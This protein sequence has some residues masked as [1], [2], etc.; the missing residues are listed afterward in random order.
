[1]IIPNQLPQIVTAARGGALQALALQAGQVLDGRVLGPAPNGGTQVQIEGK[2]LNLVLPQAAKAGDTLRFEVQ[3]S[4]AQVRLA[5]QV[6]AGKQALPAPIAN[7]PTPASAQ[8]A[9]P[10]PASAT[11]QPPAGAPQTAASSPPPAA[12]TPPGQA[13]QPAATAP[14]SPPAAATASAPTAAPAGISVPQSAPATTP[15]APAASQTTPTAAT[16]AGT[17][18]P[19]ATGTAP[20]AAAP[21]AAGSI[22]PA[23]PYAASTPTSPTANAATSGPATAA[24]SAA[25]VTTATPVVNTTPTATPAAAPN[26]PSTPQAALAQMVQAALPQQNSIASLTAALTNIAGKVAL[27]EPV[28]RAAQQVLANQVNLDGGKLN[29]AAL[30]KAFMNSGTFQEAGLARPGAPLLAPQADMKAAMLALRQT[31]TTWLGQQTPLV[32]PVSQISPPLRGQIP[33]VKALEIQPVDPAEGAETV[34]KHLLERT[35]S[36][37]SRVRLHQHAS[38]PDPTIK[39]ADWSVDLP[40]VIGG[41]QTLLQLA[42]HRDEHS[43]SEEASERGWQMRF[44][45]NLLGLGEVGAQVSLRGSA[46]GVMLWAEERSTSQALEA[47]INT[48]RD[49]LVEAG[50]EPGAVIVRHGAPPAP[51]KPASAGHIVDSRR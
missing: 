21:I 50:L 25:R 45:I 2:L 16:S 43:A 47:D 35:E 29:G 6:A 3:G 44:A 32:A 33:R 1:M 4:G 22:R 17:P 18:A 37:L 31:L 24:A 40:V 36:A 28:A 13:T 39:G 10:A 7:A 19:A 46:T 26:M 48:L 20:P 42:I 14:A 34:G 11:A 12:S 38:L 49:T 8:P 23:S 41:Q 51:P 27:P 15:A 9:G 30:Q 5:L